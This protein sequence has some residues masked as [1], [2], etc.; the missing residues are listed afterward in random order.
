MLYSNDI[1]LKPSSIS[2]YAKNLFVCEKE[3]IYHDRPE[4]VTTG[5]IVRQ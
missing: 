3:L 1:K 2:Y 5:L 4:L